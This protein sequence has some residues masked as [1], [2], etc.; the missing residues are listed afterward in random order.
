M[1][2]IFVFYLYLHF[3]SMISVFRWL[4][5][6]QERL[7]WELSCCWKQKVLGKGLHWWRRESSP[8]FNS[9]PSWGPKAS[10]HLV[11]VDFPESWLLHSIKLSFCHPGFWFTFLYGWWGFFVCYK[12]IQQWI[13][14]G[15]RWKWFISSLFHPFL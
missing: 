9:P 2:L 3:R 5:S 6:Q 14:S 15:V 1:S 4:S 7:C 12:S 10:G 11:Q 13:K 8:A